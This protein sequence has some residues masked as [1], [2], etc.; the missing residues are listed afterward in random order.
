MQ[1]IEKQDPKT[2]HQS[3]ANV[4]PEIGHV[5]Q[6]IGPTVDIRFEVGH[7]PNMLDAII[8]KVN[9]EEVVVEV[10]QHL[11]NNAVRCIALSSTDGIVRGMEAVSTGKPI[12]VPVGRETL[13]R[14]FNVLG[15]AIDEKPEPQAKKFYSIHRAAPTFEEREPATQIFETG[16]KTI[17]LLAPY[18]KGGKVGL[19]GRAGVGKTDIIQEL[20][21]NIAYQQ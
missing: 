8:I 11:G 2:A 21:R 9:K 6:V 4:K 20:I 5:T 19:F 10:A 12:I 3:A 15:K 7:L 18:Q 13:G 16:I 17:D 1:T 14:M